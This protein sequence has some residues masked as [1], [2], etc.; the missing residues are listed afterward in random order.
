MHGQCPALP[1]CVCVLGSLGWAGPG[2]GVPA[3]IDPA[4]P[5]GERRCGRRPRG[6]GLGPIPRRVGCRMGACCLCG[7]RGPERAARCSCPL[8]R[9]GSR[10]ACSGGRPGHWYS[11][12]AGHSHDGHGDSPDRPGP[13]TAASRAGCGPEWA[14][15]WAAPAAAIR[16]AAA[17]GPAQHSEFPILLLHAIDC[18]LIQ[19]GCLRGLAVTDLTGCRPPVRHWHGPCQCQ[20]YVRPPP[21]LPPRMFARSGPACAPGAGART[22]GARAGE[23]WRRG[24]KSTAAARCD[25]LVVAARSTLRRLK[26]SFGPVP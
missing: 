18:L 13:G 1:R 9:S 8:G 4:S 22:E 12:L 25:A 14:C 21:P 17:A 24:A 3:A 15:R 23:A 6:G 5:A 26:E 16:E 7:A 11:P 20:S 19:I 2:R 10:A